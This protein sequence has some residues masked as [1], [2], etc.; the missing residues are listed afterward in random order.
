MGF[1]LTTLHSFVRISTNPAIAGRVITLSDTLG[2][3]NEWLSLSHVSILYPGNRHWSLLSAI[4]SQAHATGNL[5]PDAI[6]AAIAFEHGAVVHTH[7]KGFARFA[8]LH[9]HDPLSQ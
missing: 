6:I 3:V 9:W 4:S 2:I 8:G 7:D 1:P 5:I